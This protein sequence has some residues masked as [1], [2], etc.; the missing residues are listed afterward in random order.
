MLLSPADLG[1]PHDKFPSFRRPLSLGSLGQEDHAINIAASP[2]RFQLLTCPT[3]GGKCHPADTEVIMYDGSIVQVQNIRA[4]DTLMGP[5]SLPRK[6]LE[7]CEGYDTIFDIYPIK[8]NSWGVTGQHIL[9]LVETVSGQLVDVSVLDWFDW[10]KTA[11]HTHKLVRTGVEFPKQEKELPLDP[12]FL[13]LLL[14]DGDLA[15]TWSVCKPDEEIRQAVV[16]FAE[17]IG[18]TVRT[19][20]DG[21]RHSVVKKEGQFNRWQHHPVG[22]ILKSYGLHKI[23]S[24]DRFIPQEYKVASRKERA[25]ILAGLLDT[26]GSLSNGIYD[27]ISKSSQLAEDVVFISRSLGLAAYLRPCKKKCQTG[28]GGEYYRVSISGDCCFLPIRIPRKKAKPRQ[29]KKDVLR[30]GFSVSE[31]GVDK[32]YGFVLDGD[33]RYLLSDFT[34]TH[35]S[36]IYAT[37]ALLTG[38]RTLFVTGTKG[39]QQ[40]LINDLESIGLADIRGQSNYPCLFLDDGSGCDD[41]PCHVGELCEL[42]DSGCLYYDAQFRAF[43]SQ[44]VVTNYAYWMSANRYS[45]PDSD[46]IGRFDLV[47][48]DEAHSA[49]DWLTDFCGVE[50]DRVKIRTLLGIDT[51]SGQ[52]AQ[53]K[54]VW[55]RWISRAADIAKDKQ[56][57]LKRE[58]LGNGRIKTLMELGKIVRA[59]GDLARE[60]QID[61]GNWVIEPEH[62]GVRFLP[63]WPRKYA[64]Q[65]LFRGASKIILSSA[66]MMLSSCQYLGIDPIDVDVHEV[67]STFS[68][69][70]RPFIYIPTSP[71][72]RVDYRMTEGETRLILNKLDA[73]VNGRLDRK[74]LVHSRSYERARMIVERSKHKLSMI[75]HR[76]S[77]VEEAV[78]EY[79]RA[80]APCIL[81]SP[82]I[83]EGWN[84]EGDDARWQFI[85][86]VPFIDG[87]SQLVKARL[88]SDKAYGNDVAA[89][90]IMQ[91]VG[92]IMRSMSDWGES[93]ISDSH[94]LWFRNKVKFPQWFRASWL[95]MNEI[96]KAPSLNRT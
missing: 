88:E 38:C 33:N 69:K 25:A 11:K 64:E 56:K 5:D 30:T 52:D 72:V 47:V 63:V 57:Q 15:H 39:L 84:F 3:G 82:A 59:Y 93:F 54:E 50:I 37:A 61:S 43:N 79:R 53:S 36:L 65:Y 91:M 78:R 7:V 55:S 94:W 29:Q 75:T 68:P 45:G 96:P 46:P 27:F 90:A 17:S 73:I 18:C 92:R 66:F 51:P 80:K 48:L 6:V 62:R 28:A 40:Q 21:G 70:R 89:L 34:I 71:S 31:R 41:G 58:A 23:K 26:D 10:N 24:E 32:F 95:K 83:E 2:Y 77:E 14:G 9:T 44:F 22:K 19:S 67:E 1:L 86:K 13:G 16:E 49:R 60:L 8:G 20:A 76:P 74:G 35:N 12:Y 87:R 42:K 81:V 85:W 4:G